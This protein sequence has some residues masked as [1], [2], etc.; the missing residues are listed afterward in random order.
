MSKRG[1][2]GVSVTALLAGAGLLA[3]TAGPVQ[4]TITNQSFSVDTSGT[5]PESLSF[6][7]FDMSLGTLTGIKFTLG[8][9][10][11]TELSTLSVTG[12]EG[13]GTATMSVDFEI[14]GP[15]QGGPLALSLFSGTGSATSSCTVNVIGCSSSGNDTTTPPMFTSPTT[16]S[17]A[18][19][20]APYEGSGTFTVEVDLTAPVL[21]GTCTP[22][23]NFTL[24]CTRGGRATWTGDLTVD[25]LTAS[26]PSEV[27]EPASLGLVAAGLAGLGG[28]RRRRRARR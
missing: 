18:T 11:T 7:Q 28:L 5:D 6:S 13:S 24:T 23:P 27:P 15:G 20:F 21:G 17:T 10:V 14:K 3:A 22:L 25:F 19:D 26:P 4:A 8:N 16:V 12:G 9:S 1:F 2:P